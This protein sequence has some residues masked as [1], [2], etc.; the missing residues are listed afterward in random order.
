[1]LRLFV[2]CPRVSGSVCLIVQ[3][4]TRSVRFYRYF[5]L[6]MR[7]LR[8]TAW[9]VPQAELAPDRTNASS[10]LLQNHLW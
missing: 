7:Q 3:V 6:L 4:I 1:V 8:R 9:L 10:M 5:V 2:V